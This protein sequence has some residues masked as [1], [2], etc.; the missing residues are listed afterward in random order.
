[1]CNASQPMLTFFLLY[2]VLNRNS[3]T[4]YR[5]ID[6]ISMDDL[7]FV[8]ST[9]TTKRK[10]NIHVGQR[11][12]KKKGYI[13]PRKN[14]PCVGKQRDSGWRARDYFFCNANARC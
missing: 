5:T 8:F 11:R 10:Q 9:L 12:A 13:G 3:C 6:T 1:M 14:N 2:F 4:S 7:N